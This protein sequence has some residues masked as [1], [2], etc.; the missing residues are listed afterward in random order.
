MI[1][2]SALLFLRLISKFKLNSNKH[3]EELI[4]VLPEKSE[5][6]ILEAI[7]RRIKTHAEKKIKITS[8]FNFNKNLKVIL[9][10]YSLLRKYYIS[11][12]LLKNVSIFFTHQRSDLNNNFF[13]FSYYFKRINKIY[14]MNSGTKKNSLIK[15]YSYKTSVCVG[16]FD[17]KIFKLNNSVQNNNVCFVSRFYDRKNPNLIKKIILNNPQFNFYLIGDKWEKYKDF[18]ELI[19]LSNFYYLNEDYSKYS[20]IY[21]KMSFFISVS[22]NE[23]GPIPLLET[24]ACGIYPI[25][26]NTGFAA[27]ILNRANGSIVDISNKDV[28]QEISNILKSNKIDR[29][30]LSKSVEEY[31][32]TKFTKKIIQ[33]INF[34]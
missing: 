7:A 31:T 20:I 27:D 19:N 1:K 28:D 2:F 29:L 15:K 30:N 33:Q 22:H 10:H 32:W 26:S 23:G 24:M 5:G 14:L 3:N 25:V 9:M 13:E 18:N 17:P 16:G 11:G 34:E 21:K 8:K 6:W 4:I 12:Y